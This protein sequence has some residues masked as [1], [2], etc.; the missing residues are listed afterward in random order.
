MKSLTKLCLLTSSVIVGFTF[1]MVQLSQAQ[2]ST[3][4]HKNNGAFLGHAYATTAS[5]ISA[6]V[7]ILASNLQYD[8]ATDRLFVNCGTIDS[9]GQLSGGAS[10]VPQVVAFLNAIK[11]WENS[12]P[13]YSFKVFAYLNGSLDSTNTNF[14]DVSN[15]TV[16]ANIAT[17][18]S[19]FTSTSVS[20]SYI[21]GASR[22]FDGVLIDFEPAGGTSTTATTQ[23]N[24]LKTT[25]DQITTAIGSGKLTA[26]AA[27]QYSAT[28]SSAWS[29][30][31]TFYY[32]MALHVNYIIAMTYDSGSTTGSAYQS[33]IEQQ[34]VNILQAVSGE[35][36]TDGSHSAP[37]N[38]VQILFG[39][40]AYPNN[41]P[42]HYAAAE[43]IQYAAPG[44]TSGLATLDTRALNTFGAAAVYLTTNGS[45]SDGYASWATDWNDLTQDW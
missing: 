19:K 14:I 35:Y 4:R 2:A 17:E 40:P 45:G 13:S 3:P 38:G 26:F 25:M 10:T 36:W 44:L 32:Y 41:P 31:P 27:P 37:T 21:S 1:G 30:S 12:N 11:T 6:N 8:Y 39:F 24:N 28:S 18:S 34:A 43:N 16:R 15:S 29:W 42:N 22:E 5:Y 23:F 20:G 7:P 9:S 33:W